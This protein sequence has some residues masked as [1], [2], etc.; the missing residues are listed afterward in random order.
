MSEKKVKKEE[1]VEVRINPK[2]GKPIGKPR[3][4]SKYIAEH[5]L[6]QVEEGGNT[7]MIHCNQEILFLPNID[8]KNVDEVMERIKVYLDIYAKYDLKPTVVGFALALNG[9]DR[10][11]LW[12]VANDKPYGQAGKLVDL[13]REVV[14]AIKKTYKFLEMLWEN[15]MNSGAINPVSGIFL[16]KNHF[17]YRDQSEVAVTPSLKSENDYNAEEILARY[18]EQKQLTNSEENNEKETEK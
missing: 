9:K 17:G 1:I 12:A 4:V 16:G 11:W 6:Y 2:T 7:K 18:T 3:G 13:P 14:D 5:G 8:L 15:Y 10:R